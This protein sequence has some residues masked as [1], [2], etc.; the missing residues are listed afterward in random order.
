MPATDGHAWTDPELRKAPK[1]ETSR[2]LRIV[3]FCVANAPLHKHPKEDVKQYQSTKKRACLLS[4]A[5]T[6]TNTGS[7]NS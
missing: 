7:V 4:S 3:L 1:A 2:L 5:H 6:H